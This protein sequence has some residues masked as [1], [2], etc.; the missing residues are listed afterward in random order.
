MAVGDARASLPPPTPTALLAEKCY[1]RRMVCRSFG[2]AAVFCVLVLLV[3]VACSGNVRHNEAASGGSGGTAGQTNGSGV[4]GGAASGAAGASSSGAGGGVSGAATS[5][6]SGVA[7]QATG[8]G[9]PG[10]S[11]GE[12]EGGTAGETPEGPSFWWDCPREVWGDGRCDCGCTER[13]ID[14]QTGGIDECEV[15]NGPGSCNGAECPGRIDAKDNRFCLPPPIDWHCEPRSYGDGSSCDCGCGAADLDCEDA[16]AARCTTCKLRGSCAQDRAD[17]CAT[18]ISPTNN[19]R[20]YVPE[21]WDCY[22]KYGD[23]VCDCGCGAADV[24][25]AS[26]S[27]PACEDCSQGCSGSA[28][29]GKISPTDNGVCTPPPPAWRCAEWRYF[30]SHFCDCGCGTADPDCDSAAVESCDWCNNEGSCSI[31]TCPGTVDPT[32]NAICYQPEPPEWWTCAASKYADGTRCDCGCGW[33]D[34][35]CPNDTAS[36]CDDCSSCGVCPGSISPLTNT[37]C[38]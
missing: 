37:H 15:C 28:C 38:L 33:Y 30:D 23:G 22:Q 26:S 3:A 17:G 21:N 32:H 19:A 11:G 20:C 34:P 9:P 1:R 4:G 36:V 10:G 16:S 7:G 14:C 24:D 29:P 8:G 25:C 2:V 12:S 18:A 27:L 13:D 5:G 6:G 31:Q 35:D